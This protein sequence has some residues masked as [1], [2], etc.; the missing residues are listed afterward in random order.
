MLEKALAWW[1]SLAPRDR[2]ILVLALAFLVLVGGWLI[3]FE[4]AWK[5]RAALAT[6][7]PALRGNLAQME[8]MAIESRTLGQ[9]AAQ[10]VES[11]AQLRLRIEESLRYAD[12]EPTLAQLEGSGDLLEVRFRQAPFEKWLYWLEGA[13]RDTRLRVVDLALTRESAGVVSGRVA[14]EAPRRSEQQ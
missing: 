9:Q 14:L 10:P 12:L 8:Q 13:V 6:E 1:G 4:P 7:L 3:A 2:R 5:G 11:M